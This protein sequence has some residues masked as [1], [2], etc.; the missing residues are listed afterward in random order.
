[1]SIKVSL[2]HQLIYNF[3]RPI[4]LGP[5]LLGL[6]PSPHCRTPIQNYSLKIE[7]QEHQIT[8]QQDLY[9]N[10]ISKVNFIQRTNK[11]K[12][13]V[14][15]IAE[16]KPI[17][18][19]DFL[20]EN[21][22][23]KYP[24]VYEKQL[25]KEL[26]PFLEISESGNLIQEWI[27]QNR[28]TITY[29]TNFIHLITKQLAQDITYEIRLEP[30]IQTCEETLNKKIGSCRDTAWLLVQILRHYGLASR[31]V[32][33]YLIQLKEDIPPLDGLPGPE[34]DNADL[35]AWAE[36]YL[37]GAGWIGLD[38]TSGFLAA[39]SH[40]PLVCT[41]EPTAANPV[42]GT[43]EPSES[44]L[45][46]SVTVS[47]YQEKPRPTKPYT[48]TQWQNINNLGRE[49]EK[50]LRRWGLG[51][52]TGGEPTFISIDDFESPQWRVEALGDDKRRL[53]GELLDR[54]EK[55]FAKNGGLLH[56][57]LGKWYPGEALPR[58][59]LGCY[60]RKD[61]V[62]IWGDRSLI[63]KDNRDYGHTR[64]EAE[65]FIE[66]IVQ[67][68]GVNSSCII[69]AYEQET[70]TPAG[71]VLPI[72]SV[73]KNEN[74]H[75]SSCHWQLPETKL[76]LLPGDSP[77]GFRLP[78]SSI[79]WAENLEPEAIV[80]INYPPTTPNSAFCEAPKNSIRVALTTEARQG[81]VHIFIPPMTSARSY[82]DLIA[83]IEDTAKQVKIPVI[84]EGY[85]PPGNAG[86]DGFQ[87][88]PDPGVIEVNIHPAANWDELVEITTNLYEEARLCRLGTEKY[89][90]D[91]RRISTGGGSHITIGGK[92]VSESP[93]LR[94]PDLLRSLITYW[95]HHPSL[96]Y[97]FSGL[98]V[99]PTSQ[100]PRIDEAR[101]ESLY[102]LEIA[103]QELQP[104]KEVA[105][106]LIDRLL[107]N[108]LVDVTG[109]THR[110]EFCIDKLF[111]VEHPHRQF[112][113]LE[114]RGFAM[115]P[116]A[117]MSLLQMLLIR[118]LVAWFWEQPYHRDLIRLGTM[119]HDRFFL[120]HYIGED[121]QK[122][123]GDLQSV[124]FEFEFE[125]FAPFFEFRF[126]VIGEVM[127]NSLQLELRYAIEPWHV[128]GEETTG[129]GTARYVDDS[130]ERMQVMLRGAMG[131]SP[132]QDS[133]G[134]RYVVLCNGQQIPLRSTG[135]VGEYVGAV[136]YRARKY[137]SLL[138]PAIE[139]HSPLVFEIV[140]S[141]V[142]RSIGGCSYYVS[143][144]NG[145]VY[146]Q[147]PVNSR[148]AKS[149]M[150]ERFVEMGHSSGEVELPSLRLSP[151]YPLTLDLRRVRE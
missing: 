59:S 82:L 29:T 71:Y 125:W 81:K 15:I 92:S 104:G 136:R 94:R 21:Y 49:V 51:L 32:S 135:G 100:S 3:D 12:I 97:L 98:F 93:L 65:I 38:P 46:F 67:Q 146:G 69:P 40:I 61:G 50:K 5:H 73:L 31:F 63:A 54:L 62:P 27:E 39:E 102:E 25:N 103:F 122:V 132:N 13:E 35:H 33:G 36:V 53:A 78:L 142:G 20:L 148:E 18:P 112:G 119:L 137:G 108:L 88:T 10:F 107:R 24:F 2:N 115:P 133:L 150:V 26:T 117:R 111:P 76:Y 123:I 109:N 86:I 134:S 131:D 110:T 151:E 96:S 106:E 128:L 34:S 91:G 105:P 143:P 118:G 17:N 44:N 70:E 80:D 101:H 30:G 9:G 41:P 7:P 58:W 87:V 52:T 45:E 68:L 113:L 147:F 66:T 16:L 89:Q 84:V 141:C 4:I 127:R 11:L 22:A 28:Q 124:G 14:D 140:D 6:R 130:M 99:G 37:P 138:H 83:A 48:E 8:W 129:G 23:E 47:R 79:A 90:L 55:R 145:K 116:H 19:F 42:R 85:T 74:L 149:R 120:P 144:P 139:C 72:L 77:L 56:Y 121:L 43:T 95:Q 114:F 60:W 75:W 64:K 126:P 57:G 1:M